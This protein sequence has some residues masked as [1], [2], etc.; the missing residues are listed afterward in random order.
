M[1]KKF[2][3][4]RKYLKLFKILLV[5]PRRTTN[6]VINRLYP[7]LGD[8]I[9]TGLL[10][11]RRGREYVGHMQII[12]VKNLRTPRRRPLSNVIIY[13]DVVAGEGGC[14]IRY[15]LSNHPRPDARAYVTCSECVC[16]PLGVLG[17]A[18]RKRKRDCKLT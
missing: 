17:R 18:K 5:R 1:L 8:S 9:L 6:S 15:D 14:T 13:F 2:V 3:C 12:I 7:G 10:E 4:L 16:A 11:A